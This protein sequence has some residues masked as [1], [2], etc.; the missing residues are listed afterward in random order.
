PGCLL[1]WRLRLPPKTRYP[2]RCCTI[3]ARFTL[4]SAQQTD[5]VPDPMLGRE[6]GGYR[7][8]RKIAQGGM[9]AVYEAA[10]SQSGQRAAVKVLLPELISNQEVADRFFNEAQAICAMSHPSL[11]S[12]Y[13]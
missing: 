4:G 5:S 1:P 8:V 13:E 6:L 9:G 11:V 2:P 7:I 12:I 3:G 10:H